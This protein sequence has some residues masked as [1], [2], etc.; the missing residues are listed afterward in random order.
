[1]DY[2]NAL[3]GEVICRAQPGSDIGSRLHLSVVMSYGNVLEGDDLKYSVSKKEDEKNSYLSALLPLQ[4]YSIKGGI[5]RKDVRHH[6][7]ML[8]A[9]QQH[10]VTHKDNAERFCFEDF[11]EA[12][13]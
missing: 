5:H 12:C 6:S 8:M 13:F 4:S 11:K 7:P 9:Q 2:I 1:M 3:V 10:A